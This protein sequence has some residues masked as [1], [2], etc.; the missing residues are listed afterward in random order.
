MSVV[1][2]EHV[3]VIRDGRAILNDVSWQV[4]EG[5]RW[6]VLGPNGAGKST[7][8]AVISTR[9]YPTSGSV[10]VLDE[11][12]GAVD[13][14]ELKPRIG[15]VNAGV[16]AHIPVSETV[17]N[18]V[19][20]AAWAV[21]GR[22]TEEYEAADEARAQ[23]L[24]VQFDI[25]KHAD[26]SFGTLSDGERKRTLVARAVMADPEVLFL[27]EPAAGLDLGARE[28]LVHLLG[29]L[30]NDPAAPAVVLIT[31]HVEEIP[32]GFTHALLMR[33]GAV[34]AAGPIETVLT[35][36]LLT[37]AF[38][39]ALTVTGSDGRWSARSIWS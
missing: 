4:N 38:G 34:V 29:E 7:L 23:A 20:T 26:R 36:S 6:V 27:D 28:E 8:L 5:E 37:T 2:L 19:L 31:H 18:V 15:L 17:A 3:S 11:E 30:A 25:A 33:D 35:G 24:L 13:L 9:L 32:P 22:W 16:V 21:T 12:V 39:T 1:E 14:T 10:R